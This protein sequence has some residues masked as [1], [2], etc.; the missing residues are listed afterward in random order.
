MQ[1]VDTPRTAL[2]I[3]PN[4]QAYPIDLGYKKLFHSL[5]SLLGSTR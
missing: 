4:Y 5:I 2:V 1:T 3:I